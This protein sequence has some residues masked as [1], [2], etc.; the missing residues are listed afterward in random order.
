MDINISK[1]N[2]DPLPI[3]YTNFVARRWTSTRC[4]I[5]GAVNGHRKAMFTAAV[6]SLDGAKPNTN[7]KANHNPNTNLTVLLILTLTLT[8]FPNQGYSLTLNRKIITF[9]Y[10]Y[11]PKY[12]CRHCQDGGKC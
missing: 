7:P 5:Y 10:I 2:T 1:V 3:P 8:R 4:Y 6:Q 12:N 11:V 9:T